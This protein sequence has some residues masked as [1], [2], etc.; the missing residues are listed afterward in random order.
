MLRGADQRPDA[1]FVASD[2]MAF[3]AIDTL[4]LELGLR[5]PQDVSVVGFDNV[6]QAAWGAYQLTTVAQDAVPMIEATVQMLL[7]QL[8]DDAVTAN[9]VVVPANLVVRQ[10]ARLPKPA[11]AAQPS[12][13][14]GRPK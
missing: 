11:R 2:H 14:K 8:Q 13:T 10:S 12:R 1:L 3:A 9:H 5:V 7:Q 4:R 6:P